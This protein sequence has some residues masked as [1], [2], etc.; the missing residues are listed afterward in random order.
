MTANEKKLLDLLERTLNASALT[1]DCNGF[2]VRFAPD[3]IWDEISEALAE[4]GR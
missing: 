2:A 4:N 1:T 3:A